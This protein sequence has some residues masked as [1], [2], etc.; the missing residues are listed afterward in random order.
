MDTDGIG[1]LSVILSRLGFIVF[2]FSFRDVSEENVPIVTE[3]PQY[4]DIIDDIATKFVPSM[5]SDTIIV[6]IISLKY[7][8]ACDM[9][10]NHANGSFCIHGAS[11][12]L[13][14]ILMGQQLSSAL[15]PF[16]ISVGKNQKQIEYQQMI[17]MLGN[18]PPCTK[19]I[20][21]N[22]KNIQKDGKNCDKGKNDKSSGDT[23]NDGNSIKISETALPG[24]ITCGQRMNVILIRDRSENMLFYEEI[25]SKFDVPCEDITIDVAIVGVSNTS[26]L[27]FGINGISTTLPNNNPISILTA[28][29]NAEAGV[30]SSTKAKGS[31][32]ER[33]GILKNTAID[34]AINA[35]EQSGNGQTLSHPSVLTLDKFTTILETDKVHYSIISGAN[36]SNA[37]TQSATIKLQVISHIISGDTDGDSKHKMKL[38]ID[39]SDGKFDVNEDN[40]HTAAVTQ[41]SLNAQSGLYEG[42]SSVIGNYDSEGNQKRIVAF[43]YCDI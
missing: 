39:I 21:N 8:L 32:S 34:Y 31:I 29:S 5:I 27:S 14:S 19:D 23:S 1:T 4:I 2:D 22:I 40:Q 9:T 7:A 36:N 6:K 13:Q 3:S 24:F 38:F 16:N 30:E 10:F 12:L 33:F 28:R 17:E 43:P 37:Y 11:N 18:T 42:Q 26:S 20:N 25:I 15:S 41:H 35:L